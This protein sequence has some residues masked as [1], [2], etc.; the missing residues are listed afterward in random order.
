MG[1]V[2]ARGLAKK[3]ADQIGI[4]QKNRVN[5]LS[6]GADPTGTVN[7]TQAFKDAITEIESKITSDASIFSGNNEGN[8]VIEL[9]AGTFLITDDDPRLLSL[10]TLVTRGLTFKGA[11]RGVTKVVFKP[12][13]SNG[14]LFYNNNKWLHL[15]FEGI[16]FIGDITKS[17]NFMYSYSTSAAQNYTFD[18]C[19]FFSFNYGWKLEGTNVNSEMTWF[20]CGFYY[21]WNKILYAESSVASDQFL[22]Y[23][24]FA[25][26][27]EIAAGDFIH[28]DKGGSINVWGGS[29][30][31]TSSAG[32]TFFRL[33]GNTHAYGVQR[34]LC[35]G[36]RFEHKYNTSALVECDWNDGVVSFINCDTG[37][38]TGITGA[39]TMKIAK[40]TSN[41]QKMPVVK[42]DNCSLM[43][44]HEYVYNTNSFNYPHN[45]VYENCEFTNATKRSD[46]IVYTALGSNPAGKP[47]ITFRNC[48]GI[49]NSQK[50]IWEGI[51]NFEKAS[52]A[53][54]TKKTISL[55][56]ADSKF[57]TNGGTVDVYLPLNALVTKVILHSPSGAVTETDTATFSVQTYEATPTTLATITATNHAQGFS[58]NQDVLFA[59]TDDD[60][61]HL[62]LVAGSDVSQFN[63]SA[64]CLIEYIG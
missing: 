7:A 57:P 39:S 54:S 1:D 52:V 5:V 62:K 46:F 48:R 13:A 32:G 51:Y 56:G 3:N 53:V 9:P 10:T 59:C 58:L 29:F 22:N 27:V 19:D 25:C 23:N 15:H 43:G 42:F 44:Q 38:Q 16:S 30:I 60:K 47:A 2:I 12:T 17:T 34:F 20:H 55:K 50:E 24:F 4:V 28:F 14:Y 21:T 26:Q 61:R 63:G 8:A 33:K 35:V 49:G 6:K 18:K 37:S 41:N 45:V 31:H 40:F 64:Y 11:G 36:A